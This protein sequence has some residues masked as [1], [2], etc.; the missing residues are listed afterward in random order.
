MFFD[1]NQPL[2]TDGQPLVSS[3]ADFLSPSLWNG[4]RINSDQPLAMFL[5]PAV[6]LLSVFLYLLSEPLFN[7]IRN[8]FNVQRDS[9]LFKSIIFCHNVFLAVFSC[10]V[11]IETWP[12]MFAALMQSNGGF[13]WL[14]CSKEVWNDSANGIAI[15]AVIFYVSKFYEFIDTWVLVLKNS[16][17][18]HAPSF[19]QKFHHFGI[20]LTMYAGVISE[21][22]WLI[23]CLCLNSTIHTMMYTYYALAT[24]GYKSPWA[25]VL[26]N[27][28]M[29]QFMTGITMSSCI[30]FF[31]TCSSATAASKGS[32]LSIQIYAACLIYL[33]NE[34]AKKKYASKKKKK[35][36]EQSKRD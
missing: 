23:W 31:E 17:G 30:F 29:L 4:E 35:E 25:K 19:L 7:A 18:K 26:T 12:L 16:D 15:W 5:H 11:A 9:P 3:L 2:T 33:F 1:N 20:A 34:M 10:W 8:T 36:S 27:L 6:P 22:N 13:Q 14:H 24:L 21:S 32:L 28:Q